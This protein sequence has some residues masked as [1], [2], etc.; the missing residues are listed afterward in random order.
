MGASASAKHSFSRST[1]A[2]VPLRSTSSSVAARAASASPL[3]SAARRM[4]R[5]TSSAAPVLAPTTAWRTREEG[6]WRNA[7]A[8]AASGSSAPAILSSA[9][10]ATLRN[11]SSLSSLRRAMAPSAS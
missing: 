8:A 11:C 2:G 4:A 9:C 7:C 5:V 1:P 6:A 3:L 10:R